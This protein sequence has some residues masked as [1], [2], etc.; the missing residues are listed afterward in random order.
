MKTPI[1]LCILSLAAAISHAQPTG[2]A[3]ASPDGCKVWTPALLR[4]P[5]YVPHY[6]GPC[7]KGLAQGK[8]ELRWAYR[9]PAIAQPKATWTGYFQDGVFVGDAP[10][11]HQIEPQSDPDEYWVHF[12]A[13]PGGDVIVAARDIHEGIM[14]LCNPEYIYL[15]LNPKVVLTDDAAI[16]QGIL[17][18][19]TRVRN[20]CPNIGYPTTQVNVY[21]QPY[22]LNPDR[23]RPV[24]AARASFNWY[25]MAVAGYSNHAS[26]QLHN[27]QLAAA[28]ETRLADSQKRFND[29][30]A[31]N[32]ITTWVTTT[33]LDENPF[34]YEGKTV[35]VVVELE[36][37]LSADTALVTSG[38]ADRGGFLQLH[39][40]TPDFPDHT[41]SVVIAARVGKREL[42]TGTA[43]RHPDT[44]S[45]T[46][47]DSFTC[48]RENCYDWLDWA[49]RG[50]K[51]LFTWGDPYTPTPLN[52]TPESP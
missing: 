33:Q 3:P 2:Y 43:D 27:Q 20:A 51:M 1:T 44:T 24:A 48:T 15:S 31:R 10:L 9:D 36:R 39:A 50:P 12:G 49:T 8:G 25:K 5:D 16:K 19:G 28:T 34:K 45:L 13:V 46:R 7:V 41:H 40:V 32:H 37:M 23:T 17:D 35:G 30:T 26:G 6:T 29:F 11:P 18:A 47:L 22:K 4:A 14:N 42:L 52:H 38:L 21:N